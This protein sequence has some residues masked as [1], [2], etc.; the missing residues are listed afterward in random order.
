M[1]FNVLNIDRLFM[2]EYC[3]EWIKSNNRKMFSRTT[4]VRTIFFGGKVYSKFREIIPTLKVRLAK[5][6]LENYYDRLQNPDYQKVYT[7]NKFI[8]ES[9][10][11]KI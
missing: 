10:R 6:Y 3:L 2:V 11:K 7:R 5:V 1:V 8:L 4:I 9:R